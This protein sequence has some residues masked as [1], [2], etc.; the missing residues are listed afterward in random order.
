MREED[1][2]TP[3]TRRM[4]ADLL[5]GVYD[6]SLYSDEMNLKQ[7]EK[8]LKDVAT[9]VIQTEDLLEAVDSKLDAAH[10]KKLVEKLSEAL[11][12]TNQAID[13]AQEESSRIQDT[14][15]TEIESLRKQ[16]VKIRTAAAQ[17]SDELEELQLEVVD[18]EAFIANL[19]SRLSAID[20]SLITRDSLGDL[21]ACPLCSANV[22]QIDGEVKCEFSGKKIPGDFGKANMLKMK[23]ELRFQLKESASLQRERKNEIQAL[24]EKL[25]TLTIEGNQH[26]RTY[27][28]RLRAV[29][30]A[31]DNRLDE[32]YQRKGGLEAEISNTAHLGKYLDV[33]TNLKKRELE[34]RRFKAEIE[35]SIKTKR[36]RQAG[37]RDQ[38]LFEVKSL[39]VD[40]LGQ[41]L[42]RQDEFDNVQSLD[43][44]FDKNTYLLN[45]RNN[46]SASSNAVLKNAIHFGIHFAATEDDAF[47][48]PRFILCDNAEDGGME[49]ERSQN[50]QQVIAAM[51]ALGTKS[52]QAIISTSMIHPDL[53]TEN[54]CVGPE[55]SKENKSLRLPKELQDAA[56]AAEP[57]EQMDDGDGTSDESGGEERPFTAG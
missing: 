49:K 20:E 27:R 50:F 54:F 53:N 24:G 29:K 11:E 45:G 35:E 22:S 12:E 3:L 34:L 33:L 5:F 23:E 28:Q 32:L 26:S 17:V 2:D 15:S 56:I 10:L 52:F 48:Y 37:R 4:I 16:I 39:V 8:E 31:R 43:L 1:W 19:T 38:A 55:Y 41:D 7:R 30:T 21:P 47:R 14:S 18:S 13:R 46:F 57:A 9:Q 44:L 6:D 36:R 25:A 40:I 51:A 42:K